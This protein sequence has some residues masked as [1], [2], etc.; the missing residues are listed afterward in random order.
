[1]AEQ[2]NKSAKMLCCV[3]KAE[4]NRDVWQKLA[5]FLGSFSQRTG[6]AGHVAN[7]LDPD[8]WLPGGARSG[9]YPGADRSFS[10]D[11]GGRWCRHGF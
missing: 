4:D 6:M 7:I 1:M 3:R 11:G 9:L 2:G 10:E 5:Q 8:T